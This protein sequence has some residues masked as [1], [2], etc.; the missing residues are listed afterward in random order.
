M[1]HRVLAESRRRQSYQPVRTS[2]AWTMVGGPKLPT[3]RGR[4]KGKRLQTETTQ[5]ERRLC[6][7]P[8]GA[9]FY[10]LICRRP[11]PVPSLEPDT[12]LPERNIR[13]C[14]MYASTMVQPRAGFQTAGET[15][16]QHLF[17]LALAH[18]P[19]APPVSF[20][21]KFQMLAATVANQLW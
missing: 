2:R 1:T 13:A 12:I 5:P 19:A 10:E 14:L 3:N 6:G 20:G 21:W 8:P 4:R 7:V 17:Q 9:R 15:A 18:V 11:L 16:C